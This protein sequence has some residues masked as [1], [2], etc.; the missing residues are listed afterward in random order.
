MR[1][2]VLLEHLINGQIDHL[3][4]MLERDAED[5]RR[6]IT[7]RL[8]PEAHLDSPGAW[9]ATRLPDHRAHYLTHEG[10]IGGGRGEV[11]CRARGTC[12]ITLATPEAVH[13]VLR[14]E[15][16]AQ[17]SL[18][19]IGEAGSDGQWRVTIGPDSLGGE[20]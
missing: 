1:R 2:F 16:I 8:P 12:A 17:P 11:R 4:L 14:R 10:D 9:P 20:A 5:D 7:F 6:L 13:A 3:D 19:V 15:D 18:A